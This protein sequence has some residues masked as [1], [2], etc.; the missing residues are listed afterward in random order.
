MLIQMR[1]LDA[2][3]MMVACCQSMHDNRLQ[4]A[5]V[6]GIPLVLPSRS[7]GAPLHATRDLFVDASDFLHVHSCPSCSTC[8]LVL[9]LYP[10]RS[11]HI[12]PVT[13][14]RY[15]VSRSLNCIPHLAWCPTTG[16]MRP[17]RASCAIC[18]ETLFNKLD[19]LDDVVPIVA[20][21]CG[22]LLLKLSK[23]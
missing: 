3:S 13:A 23:P 17:D 1:M 16:S 21:G 10:I 6:N 18:M 5:S 7:R 14:F 2:K 8:Y 11:T 19:D 22:E 15:L 9:L 4:R 20:P 12:G